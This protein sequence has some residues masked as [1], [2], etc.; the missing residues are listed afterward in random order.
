[1]CA[2]QDRVSASKYIVDLA[3]GVPQ[4]IVPH[5]AGQFLSVFMHGAG[6]ARRRPK[7][8]ARSLQYKSHPTFPG[9]R[10]PL[11]GSPGLPDSDDPGEERDPDAALLR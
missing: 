6:Q 10:L 5:P 11:K 4:D 2:N 9:D 3:R 8:A 7:D 1:M